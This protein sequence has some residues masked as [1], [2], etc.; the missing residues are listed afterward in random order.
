[1]TNNK[2]YWALFVFIWIFIILLFTKW[3]YDQFQ[4]LTTEKEALQISLDEKRKQE[5]ELKSI[6][7]YLTDKKKVEEVVTEISGNKEKLEKMKADIPKYAKWV[8]EDEVLKYVYD[9][10]SRT[11][12]SRIT[13]LSISSWVVWQMQ[14]LESDINLSIELPNEAVL[15][16][17]LTKLYNSEEYKFFI[18]TLNYQEKEQVLGDNTIPSIQVQIPLKVYYK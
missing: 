8:K 6:D 10:I 1:M 2:L 18:P 16:N 13:N 12:Q 9:L 15:R 4:L 5:N 11:S 14:F 7:L 3:Q 17:L